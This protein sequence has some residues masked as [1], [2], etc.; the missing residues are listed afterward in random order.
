MAKYVTHN[1]STEFHAI[2]SRRSHKKTV[3]LRRI[4]K[5]GKP[6]AAMEYEMYSDKTAEDV[7]ARLEQ[8]NPGDHWVLA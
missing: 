2:M 8:N 4:L 6:G 1:T 3:T 5:S 7:I